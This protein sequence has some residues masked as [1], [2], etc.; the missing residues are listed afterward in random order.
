MTK[1]KTRK[2]KVTKLLEIARAQLGKPYKYGAYAAKDINENPDSFDCSSFV[3]FCFKSIGFNNF[4]RSSIEQ[5]TFPGIE[6]SSVEEMGPGDLVFFEG[7]QGHY[8]H[9]LF[10]GRKIY[11]GHVAICIKKSQIIHA[12]D[13]DHVSGVVIQELEEL[14]NY[15]NWPNNIVMIKRY[16]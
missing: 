9:G 8:R 5:A 11:I 2:E 12:V 10:G 7:T 14:P 13:R 3:Q 16:F 15:P 4:P 1:I 6:I